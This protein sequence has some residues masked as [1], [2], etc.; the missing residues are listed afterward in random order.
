MGINFIKE[1]VT[2]APQQKAGTDIV[3][4]LERYG[5]ISHRSEGT[6]DLE[7]AG[8]FIK[9]L[10][11]WGHE[12]VL[13]HESFTVKI[14]CSRA[15]SHEIV[16]HRIGTA[17]TQESTR[18]CNYFNDIAFIEPDEVQPSETGSLKQ[19]SIF[20]TACKQAWEAYMQLCEGNTVKPET[21]RDI[22]PNALATTLYMTA[23]IREWRHIIKLRTS[24]AAHPAIRKLFKDVLNLLK[25][26]IPFCFDDL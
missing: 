19:S 15:I 2:V 11:S 20:R 4:N 18:Y 3:L 7:D 13:E 16:R 25:A 14:T 8:I 12:S 24:N 10:I 26:E 21:A 1:Q 23:N 22:L 6:G 5:R 9:K 17:F